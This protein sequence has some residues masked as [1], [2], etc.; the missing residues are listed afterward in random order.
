MLSF[1][2]K[3]YQFFLAQSIVCSIASSAVFN[4]CMAAV[5][6]WF[7]K[8]RATAYGIMVT[9]SSLGGAL[10]PIFMHSLVKQI[11]FPWMIRTMACIF[12]TLLAIACCTVK[13]RLPPRPRPFKI[14]EYV[15]SFKD[16]RMAVTMAGMF[17]FLMG[18]SLPF[19]Y[20]LL[21]AKAAGISPS[22]IPCLLSILNAVRYACNSISYPTLTH[23]SL[24]I[25]T[26]HK[27]LTYLFI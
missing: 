23:T 10:L 25:Q 19:N 21:Q 12:A 1:C 22:L 9:G 20:A 6:S 5:V 17:F 13:S 7:S 16:I 18:M 2:T 26:H 8:R 4:A 15:D 3:Y 27:S 11:G 14:A 24:L